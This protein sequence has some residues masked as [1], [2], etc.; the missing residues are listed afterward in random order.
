MVSNSDLRLQQV[1]L[2]LDLHD[3][4]DKQRALKRVTGI[5]GVDS[6]SMDMKEK[7]LTVTG[8][9]DPVKVVSKLR[10]LFHT[11]IVSV[12]E[13]KKDGEGGKDKKTPDPV[14]AVPVYYNQQHYPNGYYQNYNYAPYPKSY[15]YNSYGRYAQVP[16]D[17]PNACKVVLK[18]DM[19]GDKDK[20]K[21]MKI[22]SGL[23]GVDSIATDLKES[24]LTVTGSIDPV[25]VVSKLRKSFRRTEI[26]TVGPA[27]A[28]EKKGDPNQKKEDQTKNGTK[29][30]NQQQQQQQ[31][32]S[33]NNANK[34]KDS[35]S[36]SSSSAAVPG[37]SYERSNNYPQ[38]HHHY[39]QH[40]HHHM[41]NYYYA[42]SAEEDPNACVIC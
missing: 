2:K 21:A 13:P 27:T 3:D 7:K 24:K 9:V 19:L 42:R 15:S 40:Q 1:V 22:V 4:K 39:P 41:P 17:D 16:G 31:G 29:G 26:V 34:K 30:E 32:Q 14:P 35:S 28:P 23:S 11:E 33:N 5:S 20:Q 8:D 37:N 25:N 18:L 38:Q 6:V 12:G 10:K 36:S